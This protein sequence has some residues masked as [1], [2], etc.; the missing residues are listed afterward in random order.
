[1]FNKKKWENANEVDRAANK[2]S[3]VTYDIDWDAANEGNTPAWDTA[4]DAWSAYEIARDAWDDA[5][6]AWNTAEN[7]CDNSPIDSEFLN[8]ARDAVKSVYI[9]ASEALNAANK[10]AEDAEQAID[11]VK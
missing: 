6:D 8:A 4:R 3:I 5:W 9:D 7:A 1:M 10:V 11:E 2:V